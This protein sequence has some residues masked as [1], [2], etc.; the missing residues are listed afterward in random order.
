MAWKKNTLEKVLHNISYHP[1]KRLDI[2]SKL[3]LDQQA[4]IILRLTKHI[5][6]DIVSKLK[7]EKLVSLVEHLDPDEA[8]DVM[9]LLPERERKSV[10]KKIN[11]KLQEDVSFL[12]RFDPQT[13][14]GLMNVDYIQVRADD[15]IS[16]VAKQLK[17]HEKR[18]GKLPAI[19]VMEDGRLIGYLPGHELGYG[20]KNEK[21]KKYMRKIRTV[22]HDAETEDVIETFR[23]H[24]HN[25]IAVLGDTKEV[26]GIIYSDDILRAMHEKGASSLLDFAGVHKEESVFDSAGQKV[27]FRYKWLILNLATAFLAAFTVGL[28]DETISKYIL[29]AVYM[30]IVAGM[31]G[32]SATQT[33]AV[34]VRGITLRQ[35]SLRTM[36]RT[37][38]SELGSGFVNGAINGAII[39]GVVYW[40]DGDPK[41]GLI[42]AAAMIINLLIAALF[43]T[44]TPLLLKKLGKD[45]ALSATVFITT[46]TDVFGFLV[47]L[48]LATIILK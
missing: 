12:L 43:G 7:R 33:L 31:G 26:L 28:F 37:L 15:S 36:W 6:Y 42:L 23:Q 4:D 21:A 20:H 34:L 18:T 45:P 10:I 9:R 19:L 39:A 47:F 41:I 16:R 5:Q 30:P 17:V 32:N 29:L 3:S 35:I 2:F 8:T 38:K 46:A 27:R 40:K 44:V 1:D 24:P 22:Q 25:K 14:A 11:K 48:G 13:A